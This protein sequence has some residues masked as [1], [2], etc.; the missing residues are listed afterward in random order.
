MLSFALEAKFNGKDIFD[1]EAIF[2]HELPQSGLSYRQ[3]L[4]WVY[5]AWRD[6][7]SVWEFS[8]KPGWYQSFIVAAHR[9][10]RQ[11]EAVL[12]EDRDVRFKRE[13]AQREAVQLAQQMQGGFH[14]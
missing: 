10:E 8:Q 13:Q 11:I 14:R 9:T 5:A 1:P 7:M 12:A 4:E 3:E 6:N 2:G